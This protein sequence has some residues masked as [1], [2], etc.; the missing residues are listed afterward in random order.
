MGLTRGKLWCL[1][2]HSSVGCSLFVA[3][4]VVFLAPSSVALAV[5][6]LVGALIGL[7]LP[8]NPD[9]IV[10]VR[11]GL[12]LATPLAATQGLALLPLA[13][14]V[15][16]SPSAAWL[17]GLLQASLLVAYSAA[18]IDTILAGGLPSAGYDDVKGGCVRL[19]IHS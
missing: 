1:S 18:V 7:L 6:V 15:A 16:A 11:F 2:R 17:D 9:H 14:A 3:L 10:P 5:V 8:E 4:L 12:L 19:S 13:I